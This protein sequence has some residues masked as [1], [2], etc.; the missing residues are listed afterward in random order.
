MT[1]FGLICLSLALA[2]TTYS[3]F[4]LGLGIARTDDRLVASGRKGVHASTA[5]LS[6]AV[7]ALICALLTRDFQ[8][9]YVASHTSRD[10]STLYTLAALWAGQPGSLLF[11][12]WLLSLF[13]SVVLLLDQRSQHTLWPYSALFLA[14]TEALFLMPLIFATNPFWRLDWIPTDGLGMNPLLQDP[15]M[16]WHRPVL[17]AG[18]GGFTVAF[19]LYTGALVSGRL[20]ERHLDKVRGWALF[21]WLCLGMATLLGAQW[22][23]VQLGGGGLAPWHPVENASLI[24]WLTGAAFLHSLV[25]QLRRKTMKLW[26]MAL[27]LLNFVLCVLGVF[28]TLGGIT[29]YMRAA[30]VPGG[31]GL[32]LLAFVGLILV[33]AGLLLVKRLLQSRGRREWGSLISRQ[34]SVVLAIIL[35][36]A[37]SLAIFLDRLS[38]LVSRASTVNPSSDYS[39]WSSA[40]ILGLLMV[41][42]GICP[43]TGRR[44]ST[45]KGLVRRL[46]V[47][48]FAALVVAVSQFLA[49]LTNPFASLAFAICAFTLVGTL[50]AFFQGLRADFRA[51]KKSDVLTSGSTIQRQRR[52][53]GGHV[54]HVGIVVIAIGVTGSSAY[55]E[56]KQAVLEQGASLIVGDYSLR[57]DDF[58][59]YPAEG[60]DVAAAT[61]SIFQGER[62]VAVLVPE[63]HFHR[64]AQ[65]A[66]SAA[67]IRATLKETLYAALIGWEDTDYTIT[68]QV[69]V[70]PLA[71]WA[72]LGGS[73]VLLGT[74]IAVGPG[75]R[76][77]ILEDQVEEEIM[78]V[79]RAGGVSKVEPAP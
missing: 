31:L 59:F 35:L 27:S 39:D 41:L 37:A 9:D 4:A 2:T 42:M 1:E 17:Y 28:I 77:Q 78:R 79:R 74:A 76:E 7:L 61:L 65:Q 16:L 48:F 47:P 66:A 14:S 43:F 75:S 46:A 13:A 26:N 55:K 68:L 19:G 21:S 50:L 58:S 12:T 63:R 73:L 6:L 36:V 23:Y 45:V 10:L 64:S 5:L 29:T 53:Y 72:W 15:V 67:A 34:S 38:P 25:M 22:A 60:K 30:N 18:Y 69:T 44:D 32:Y 54:V 11:W 70:S 20:E 8:V 56:E 51:W 57:Y 33:G 52:R 71:V 40:L 3:I 62:Q 49:G 24:P